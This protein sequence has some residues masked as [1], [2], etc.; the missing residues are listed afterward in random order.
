MASNVLSALFIP[1]LPVLVSL[2]Q[3]SQG[4]R[5]NRLALVTLP[6][7]MGRLGDT[8]LHV[9]LNRK[10]QIV[11]PLTTVTVPRVLSVNCKLVIVIMNALV[12]ISR[13]ISCL[14]YLI[15]AADK[16]NIQVQ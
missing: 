15:S 6:V 7:V 4:T 16:P 14:M 1:W 13:P 11:A 3:E 9:N 12:V 2:P 8:S 5:F 10:I